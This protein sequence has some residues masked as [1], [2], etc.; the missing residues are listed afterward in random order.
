[1][2]SKN[3]VNNMR[4]FP[5]ENDRNEEQE[6]EDMPFGIKTTAGSVRQASIQQAKDNVDNSVVEEDGILE[7]SGAEDEA[8]VEEEE[9]VMLENWGE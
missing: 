8:L 7:D 9:I 6:Y 5:V 1:M 3:I 2:N 4:N